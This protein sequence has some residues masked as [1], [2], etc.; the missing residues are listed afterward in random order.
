MGT[1][2]ALMGCER[3]NQK[4]VV[5]VCLTTDHRYGNAWIGQAKG[6]FGALMGYKKSTMYKHNN[7]V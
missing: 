1:F 3:D 6:T 7:S 5:T 2:G 4:Q